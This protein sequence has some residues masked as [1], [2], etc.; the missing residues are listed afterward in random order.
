MLVLTSTAKLEEGT[1]EPLQIAMSRIGH[2]HEEA[3]T[4]PAKEDGQKDG[5]PEP[6][7]VQKDP[8][9]GNNSEDEAQTD[10]DSM[11]VEVE[12]DLHTERLDGAVTYEGIQD[13][14]ERLARDHGITQ[15]PDSQRIVEG[16][17]DGGSDDDCTSNPTDVASKR[18][19]VSSIASALSE[20]SIL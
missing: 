11:E 18:K 8:E 17:K 19:R 3:L 20:V 9:E 2:E 12:K 7:Q 5:Q 16:S 14:C 1:S 4:Q 10:N 13:F 6:V 15:G